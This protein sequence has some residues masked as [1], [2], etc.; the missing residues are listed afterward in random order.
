MSERFLQAFIVSPT[1]LAALLGTSTL[2]LAAIKK[3]VSKQ[4]WRD[5]VLTAGQ[6]D[7]AEGRT[8][9]EEGLAGFAAGEPPSDA[10]ENRLVTL[11]L[12]A[13]A[14]QLKPHTVRCDH[15]SA[16][17][18]FGLWNPA[19]ELLGMKKIAKQWGGSTFAWPYKKAE[20]SWPILTLLD[21]KSLVLWQR[22][23]GTDWRAKLKTLTASDFE[24][25]ADDSYTYWQEQVATHVGALEKWVTRTLG[26]TKVRKAVAASANSLVLIV[27]GDQ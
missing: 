14:E 1:K 22:E 2:G 16:E 8:I 23:L 17:K 18:V 3:A 11:V 25:G 12:H 10:R 4:I 9:V 13:V 21:P 26:T 20:E 19:F 7:A 24:P 6:G 15:M 5:V 27:D